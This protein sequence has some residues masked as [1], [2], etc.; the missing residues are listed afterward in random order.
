M[1]FEIVNPTDIHL[2]LDVF[3]KDV[4][5]LAIGQ[6]LV[7]YTNSNPTR[8]Y[9]C[10]IILISKEISEDK[11]F[12]VHCHFENYDKEL[13]PGMF[14][15][16]EIEV[17]SKDS[18]VLPSEAIVNYENKKYVFIQSKRN[19]FQISEI[20]TGGSENGYIEIGDSSINALKGQNIVVKG[21][22]SLLMKMKNTG[23]EE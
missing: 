7:A 6:T 5:K 17:Q 1:I 14:M 18:Y 12:E 10:K 2:A 23:E 11:S 4:S 19:Q 8:K 22:Y 3:E 9:L 13:L 15:N 21:A 20:Q 16:A